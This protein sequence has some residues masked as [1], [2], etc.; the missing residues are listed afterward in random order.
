MSRIGKQPIALPAGVTVKADADGLVTVTGPKGTLTQN[1]SPDITVKTEGGQII[2]ELLPRGGIAL[3]GIAGAGAQRFQ[4]RRALGE[5]IESPI[6]AAQ[7]VLRF[8]R[9]A[10][11]DQRNL[12]G[13]RR[14]D[15]RLSGQ[16]RERG[17]TDQ[18]Q[19]E[20]GADSGRGRFPQ[21]GQPPEPDEAIMQYRHPIHFS[22][23]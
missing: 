21:Q 11:D 3:G 18:A 7:G 1:I 2:V 6:L 15:H 4:L 16:Q 8:Q 13:G 23:S 5:R 12:F 19:H 14:R 17:G 9:D 22:P 10:L 20:E